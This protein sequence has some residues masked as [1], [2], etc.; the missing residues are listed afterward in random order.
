M[1]L[2]IWIQ[3]WHKCLFL[4]A[5]VPPCR[6]NSEA[7]MPDKMAQMPEDLNQK[8]AQMPNPPKVRE[9]MIREFHSSIH[10]L[11]HPK[12]T[13]RQRPFPPEER[14]SRPRAATTG[15]F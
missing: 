7:Q 1:M 11:P 4:T 8:K 10:K 3:I 5:I 13:S 12:E 14:H 9:V 6:K 15:V 2:V